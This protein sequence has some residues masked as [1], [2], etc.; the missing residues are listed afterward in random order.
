MRLRTAAALAG[1]VL[2][3][4]CSGGSEPQVLPSLTPTPSA[5]VVPVVVPPAAR[6]HDA[7]GAAAFVRFYYA[8]FN[9]ALHEADASRL[10]G[11]SDPECGTCQR[12]I[13]SVNDLAHDGQKLQGIAVRVL[14]AEAPPEVN[15]FIAVD[16]FMDAPARVLVDSSGEI[17]RRLPASPRAHKTVTVK[18]VAAGWVLRAVKEAA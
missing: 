5:S 10:T 8:Q 3:T 4:A 11:L 2:L 15:G 18:R 13:A 14:S 16:V 12:Y 6:V 17:V 9:A 1:L 7:F